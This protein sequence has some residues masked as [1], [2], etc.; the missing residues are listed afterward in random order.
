MGGGTGGAAREEE[1]GKARERV[2]LYIISSLLS[3]PPIP[4]YHLD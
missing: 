2:Y 1:E 3:S 4:S